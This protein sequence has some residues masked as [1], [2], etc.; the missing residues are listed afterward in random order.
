MDELKSHPRERLA[1]ARDRLIVALDLPSAHS[2]LR[3][4][5]QLEGTCEWFKVGLELYLA[6]GKTVLEELARRGHSIFLDLKLHDIP[7]T[8]ASAVRTLSASGVS[9]LTV[10]AAGGPSMLAAAVE[11]AG[12]QPHPPRLLAVTVLTSFDQQ[13]L[14]AVGISASASEQVLRLALMAQASGITGLICS[15]AEVALLRREPAMSAT[16]FLLVTPGIRPAG[17]A[18]NDQ[19]RIATPATAIASGASMLV[20]GRPITQAADPAN[21]ATAILDEIIE[22]LHGRSL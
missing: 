6:D 12:A 19:K 2:A 18:S 20:V 22:G 15:P 13:Q 9:L 7:N 8:V 14:N 17:T 21:A 16:D 3:L 4:V 1:S 5:D 10:H 11:A